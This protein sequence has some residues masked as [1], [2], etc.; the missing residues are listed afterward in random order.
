M[1]GY[2]RKCPYIWRSWRFLKLI[3]NMKLARGCDG[4]MASSHSVAGAM[5]RRVCPD[6]IFKK[7][8][9]VY[10]LMNPRSKIWYLEVKKGESALVKSMIL[11]LRNLPIL[12]LHVK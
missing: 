4:C 6:E 7:D 12:L 1:H 8:I 11:Q 10:I 2:P 9:Q 5:K 3:G